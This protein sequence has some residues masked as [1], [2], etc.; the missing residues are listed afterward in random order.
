MRT[1]S[2]ENSA[3][4]DEVL[5]N[6]LLDGCSKAGKLDLAFQLFHQMQTEGLSPSTITFNSLIDACVRANQIQEGWKVLRTM[7]SMGVEPDN[8]TYSTLF[9]GIKH[10]SQ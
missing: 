3:K 6:S 2:S 10:E 7:Q 8:Y 4:P 5:Y 9:K 1:S